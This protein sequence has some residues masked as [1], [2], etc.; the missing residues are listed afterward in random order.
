MTIAIDRGV[1]SNSGGDA[2]HGAAILNARASRRD[3][4]VPFDVRTTIGGKDRSRHDGRHEA[5][6]RFNI[7]TAATATATV[8]GIVRARSRGGVLDNRDYAAPVLS[9]LSAAPRQRA[10]FPIARAIE[11]RLAGCDGVCATIRRRPAWKSSGSRPWD[12]TF[13]PSAA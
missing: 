11:V 10:R 8:R 2:R 3:G 6:L 7:A 5:G 4:N 9:P 12:A 13:T 1:A